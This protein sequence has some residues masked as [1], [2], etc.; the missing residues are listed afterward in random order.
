MD[1]RDRIRAQ[2][3]GPQAP[4]ADVIDELAQ[5]AA[6]A[7]QSAR[8]EGCSAEEAERRLQDQLSAWSR[9]AS[10][11]QRRVRRQAPPVPPPATTGV[12]AGLMQD[13]R[14]AFRMMLRDRSHTLLVIATMAL[15]IAAATVLFSVTYGVLLK[16]LP[17]P[18]SDRLVRLYETRQ[19][20]TRPAAFFT[21]ATYLAWRESATTIDGLAGWSPSLRIVEGGGDAER[22][23]IASVTPTVF[24]VLRARPQ[25]GTAFAARPDGSPADDRQVLLSHGFWRERFG[26]RA[27]VVGRTLRIDNENYRVSGVMPASFAFPDSEV[28]A[29]VPFD[30]PPVVGKEPGMRSL[31]MFAGIARLK[32]GAT[33]AQAAAEATARG[34]AAPDPGIVAVAVFG[35][36][37]PVE[38]QAVPLLDSIAG[39]V[40]PA[41]VVFLVAVGLLLATATA[42]VASLQL[43][44]A[45]ARRREV[46]LRS[47]IGA[48]A[49][50]IVRQFIVESLLPGA[51]GGLAGLVLAS[52]LMRGLPALLPADFPRIADIAVDWRVAA[53]ALAVAGLASVV[54]GL[55]PALQAR[56]VDLLSALNE[57]SLAPVGASPR[58]PVARARAAIMAGQIAVACILLVAAALLA[59]SFVEM[60]QADRGYDPSNVLTS[61]LV[62]PDAV[63]T[64][65]ARTEAI[66]V[67]LERLRHVPGVTHAAFTTSLPLAA[68][69]MLSSF[70][71]RSS[72]TGREVRVQTSIR[73]VSPDYF[74]AL[75]VRLASG[76]VFNEGDRDT[77][78][79]VAI[80]N[81]AFAREYFDDTP[82]DER[83]PIN[84]RGEVTT[85]RVVGVIEDVRH[86]G[87][88]EPPRRELYRA[89]AQLP[90]GVQ[91]DEPMLILRTN[92][93]PPTLVPDLRAIVQ[94]AAPGALVD[95]VRTMEQR[96]MS[97]L[98]RPRLYALLL[99]AFAAFALLI[100][101]VGLFGVLAYT[102]AQRSREIGV[103]AALGASPRALVIL[104]VR[105][106]L[107]VTV[108]GLMIGV[109]LAA[110]GVQTLARFLYGVEPRDPLTFAVAAGVLLLVAAA[111]SLVPARRAATVDPLKVLR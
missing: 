68:G 103:R 98:S 4:D 84:I 81:H 2:F 92:R 77:A 70:P 38:V 66:R 57:D 6:A 56:R 62:L 69:D 67:V 93:D 79:P 58:T 12:G 25:I 111:A 88:T 24:G 9:D 23:T 1:W 75:R 63:F 13:V 80:V 30:V 19:G 53:A 97:S 8:A 16:P 44:R 86:G 5:H 14:Y 82:L 107:W 73:H 108:A 101:G 43:A 29:W 10:V 34:R 71:M 22:I 87:T 20:S 89:Y 94:G 99:G 95:N 78:E 35:S 102:V 64:P 45:L 31:S 47:A 48:G 51:I 104:V 27:D 37:G 52:W 49:G 36:N 3:R 7:Y 105:Q 32:P 26:G 40:R 91:H 85:A 42:N 28:R 50:R 59:R 15:G 96:L 110:A 18:D 17:W 61:R 11:L 72:R 55:V 54:F 100:A 21:N 109:P 106:A 65:A 39:D 76:R 90:D 46:A 33:P 83:I 74:S 60:V 41:L